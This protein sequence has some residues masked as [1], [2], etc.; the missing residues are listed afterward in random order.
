MGKA[1]KKEYT[2]IKAIIMIL[3]FVA[4]IYFSFSGVNHLIQWITSGLENH[5]LRLILVIILWFCSLSTVI[6]LSVLLATIVCSILASIFGW[7]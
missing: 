4:T 1:Y 6:V 7:D 3:T 5:D 2:G